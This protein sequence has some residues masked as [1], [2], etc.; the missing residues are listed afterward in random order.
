MQKI[1]H[2][3][4]LV[5]NQTFCHTFWPPDPLSVVLYLKSILKDQT[6]DHGHCRYKKKSSI[7]MLFFYYELIFCLSI[8]SEDSV[9]NHIS[10]VVEVAVFW[11]WLTRIP[12]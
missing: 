3:I 11:N 6:I 2:W 7:D 8:I 12:C 9:M 10:S 4:H 5:S 1:L